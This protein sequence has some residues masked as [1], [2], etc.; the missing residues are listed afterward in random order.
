M[1]GVSFRSVL[2]FL[3]VIAL[4]TFFAVRMFLTA[5]LSNK[6]EQLEYSL[7]MKNSLTSANRALEQE[8]ARDESLIIIQ[9]YAQDEL[10]YVQ[11]DM[12][13][14]HYVSQLSLNDSVASLQ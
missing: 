13:S 1:E 2:L 5:Q 4:I 8:T 9:T 14:T 6:G 3:N 7:R 10:G 12:T 11:P